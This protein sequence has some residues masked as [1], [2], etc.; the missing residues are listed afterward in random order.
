MFSFLKILSHFYAISDLHL[1]A[2]SRWHSALAL[3][4]SSVVYMYSSFF[5]YFHMLPHYVRSLCVCSVFCFITHLTEIYLGIPYSLFRDSKEW[6]RIEL[7]GC[8]K[9]VGQ[10]SEQDIKWICFSWKSPQLTIA[11]GQV[12]IERTTS[13]EHEG[14]LCI[15]W[16]HTEPNV[17]V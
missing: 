1:T 8:L 13:Q 2:G 10:A 3:M 15:E 16:N 5:W 17:F 4:W 14:D 12:E 11:Q 7:W 6:W 9:C